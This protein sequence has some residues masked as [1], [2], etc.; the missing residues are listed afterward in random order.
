[1][2]IFTPFGANEGEAGR[3]ADIPGGI[4]AVMYA[5][6]FISP[7]VTAVYSWFLVFNKETI[8]SRFFGLTAAILASGLSTFVIIWAIN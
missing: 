6:A 8:D 4:L 5:A 3:G 2:L 1:M 7:F